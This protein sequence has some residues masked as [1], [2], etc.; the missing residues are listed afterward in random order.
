VSNS[1][2]DV[3]GHHLTGEKLGRARSSGI[4]APLPDE[5]GVAEGA[6]PATSPLRPSTLIAGGRYP[7]KA[8][9][10]ASMWT[11]PSSGAATKKAKKFETFRSHSEPVRRHRP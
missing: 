2:E 8:A 3:A 10:W 1:P 11:L 4:V 9:M 7:S 5:V 6:A